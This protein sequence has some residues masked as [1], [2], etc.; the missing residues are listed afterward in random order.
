MRNILILGAGKSSVALIDYL[1][2]YSVVEDWQITVA[3]MTA[4]LALLKTKNRT[5]T[6]SLGVNLAN[7][8][9][10]QAL[11]AK[12][13]IV[14]SM[15]P[16]SLHM[17]VAQDCIALKKNMV[18][19]SY[20]SDGMRALDQQ[21]KD[22]GLIFMNEMGL[23]PGI[24]HMSALQIIDELKQQ[25]KKIT[26]FESHCGGLVAP[27]SDDNPWHYKFTWNPRNVIVAGQGDGGIHYLKNG[28]HVDLNYGQLFESSSKLEVEGYGQFESYPNRDSL[29]YI[30]EYALEGIQTMYRGTLRVPAFCAGW[31]ELVKLELTDDKVVNENLSGI[32]F[33]AFFEEKCSPYLNDVSFDIRSLL[34]RTFDD[35]RI[36]PFASATNAQVLQ[37]LLEKQWVMKP[38]DKDMIVMIHQI[39]FEEEGVKKQL[40]SSLVYIGKDAEHTAMA[41]TV[42]LPVA[43]VTKMI[44]N[45][46]VERRGVLMPKYPEIYYPILE[47]LKEYG[48]EFK[49]E[50]KQIAEL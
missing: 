28:E 50:I 34:L 4:E 2:S 17:V 22:A 23:D 48:V 31:N 12:A 45:G 42:G 47:E 33:K 29:K 14:I 7:E 5:N 49:E 43:M 36:I 9:E 46:K 44:L 20:I 11:I 21:V 25:G 40:Q 27:E 38:D 18:T 37:A 16:A 24:D 32:S 10:R 19:P 39:T 35:D 1:V 30:T 15:L 3:D 8:S 13:G 26:G 41:T 6:H